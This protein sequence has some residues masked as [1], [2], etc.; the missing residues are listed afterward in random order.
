MRASNYQE[1]SSSSNHLANI[2][3]FGVPRIDRR[4]TKFILERDGTV[5]Y[6][7]VKVTRYQG[8]FV[9]KGKPR[10]TGSALK[11]A[12]AET[13]LN[14]YAINF[15]LKDEESVV[16]ACKF[17]SVEHVLPVLFLFEDYLIGGCDEEC[18]LRVLFCDED[19]APCYGGEC[20]ASYWFFED[21]NVVQFGQL[22]IDEWQ[23]CYVCADVDV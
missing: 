18:C 2:A 5:E 11:V 8:R 19:G 12:R 9:E 22:L 7:G 14:E 1:I 21:V 13:R 17:H 6:K 3:A 16:F 20:A 4:S 23:V 10:L 15:E